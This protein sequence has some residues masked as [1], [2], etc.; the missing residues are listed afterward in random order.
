M[1]HRYRHELPQLGDRLFLTDGGLETTLI[2]EE[3]FDL[4]FFAAFPL[5]EQE[6]GR[7]ALLH[8]SERY[9]EMALRRGVGL[10]LESPTWRA[11]PD[12]AAKL[13]YDE[14]R[15]SAA[16]RAAIEMLCDLRERYETTDSPMVV[17]GN[18]GPRGDGYVLSAAMSAEEAADY[19]RGQIETFRDSAADMVSAFTMTSA[20]EALGIVRAA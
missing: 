10:I 6:R 17:S 1:T 12:W 4:P 20:E 2:F 9:C 16:N 7:G 14:K 8:Y 5:L 15:L 3:G 19:H 11:N 18:I 13:G